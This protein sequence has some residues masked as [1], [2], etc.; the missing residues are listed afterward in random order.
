MD[1]N[2]EDKELL[3]YKIVRN[4]KGAVEYVFDDEK[5]E[6]EGSEAESL[7]EDEEMRKMREN[8][9]EEYEKLR[10]DILQFKVNKFGTN[11][12]MIV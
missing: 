11:N 2:E 3:N 5:K 6:S 12:P 8:Q 1:L 4:E 7:I 9:K 10:A